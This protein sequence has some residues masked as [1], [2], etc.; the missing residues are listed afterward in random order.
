MV[1]CTPAT[2]QWYVLGPA[3]W[4]LGVGPTAHLSD[5]LPPHGVMHTSA[6][7]LLGLGH[8]AT[9]IAHRV[10]GDRPWDSGRDHTGYHR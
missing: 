5:T 6:D 9:H 10:T 4:K 3:L 7:R 1:Q 2:G 8:K